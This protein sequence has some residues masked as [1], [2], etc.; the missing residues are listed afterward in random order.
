MQANCPKQ[1]LP[2]ASKTI[3]QTTID[4]LLSHGQIQQVVCAVSDGDGY[5]ADQACAQDDRVTRIS[6]GAERADSVLNALT[7]TIEHLG[8]EKASQTWVLVHDAARPCVTSKAI[9]DLLSFCQQQGHGAILA[10][11]VRD[12]MKRSN[13]GTNVAKTEPRDGL[14]HALTPQCF[15]LLELHRALSDALAQGVAITDEASAIEWAGGRVGLVAD[16]MTNLKI[17]HPQD[18]ALAELILSSQ[19][20]TS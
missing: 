9:D 15:P 1:Y 2:I 16:S 12:T 20:Q 18:L 10:A 8:A 3:L 17:T 7:A 13:D 6:G 11:P 4:R 19:E 5:Y 14:W